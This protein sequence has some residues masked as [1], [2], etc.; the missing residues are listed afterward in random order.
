MESPSPSEGTSPLIQEIDEVA[1]LSD[2]SDEQYFADDNDDY[3]L[4]DDNNG[5]DEYD[6]IDD[7]D[8]HDDFIV[9]T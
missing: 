1:L 8:D 2:E 3:V 6:C 5:S 7:I 4:A 9:I